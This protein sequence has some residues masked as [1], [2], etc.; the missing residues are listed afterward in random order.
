M[1]RIVLLSKDRVGISIDF[2]D[3]PHQIRSTILNVGFS[4]IQDALQAHW[5]IDAYLSPLDGEFDLNMAAVSADGQHYLV[6][7]MRTDCDVAF[8][9]MQCRALAYLQRTQTP[10]LVSKVVRTLEGQ[11]FER[12]SDETGDQR[13]IWVLSFI[14][15]TLYSQFEPVTVSLVRAL[16]EQVGQLHQA[17][18]GFDHPQLHRTFS[19]NLMQAEWIAGHFRH[20]ANSGRDQLL[21]SILDDYLQIKPV[22]EQLPY[23]AIHNDVN[24]NNIV[25]GHL[26][27]E[28]AQ[29]A[30]IIDFGDMCSAPRICDLAI[31]AA[32]VVLDRAD[33]G[34]AVAALVSGFHKHQP[35]TEAE[36]D[37][38]LPLLRLRLAVSV[39]TS[40]LLSLDRPNDPYLLVSQA[41]A[42]RFL[43]ADIKTHWLVERVRLACGLDV[44]S[45]AQRIRKYL[46]SQ[47]GHLLP[48]FGTSLEDVP[49]MTL[50]VDAVSIPKNPFRL[51]S[52]EATSLGGEGL[53]LGGYGEPRL[54]YTD[55]AFR[56]VPYNASK[57]RTVHLGVDVFAPA[58]TE[59]VVVLSGVVIAVENRTSHLD[60]GGLVVL[61][62]RNDEDDRFYSLYGH[63]DPESCKHLSVGHVVDAGRTIGRLGTSKC[64][65]GWAPHLHLQLA[66]SLAGMGIDWPGVACPD[67]RGLWCSLCPNPAALL[68][69]PDERIAYQPVD[70]VACRTARQKHFGP[71]L[72]LSYREP[73]LLLRGYR[74]YLF[75][76]WGR[77]YLDAYNNVPHV[78]HAHPD[79]QAVVARQLS[80]LNSNT[81][82]LHPAQSAFAEAVL[83]TMPDGL[84]VCYFVNSG[85]EANE[86]ALRLA[87]AVTGGKDV[88]TPNHGYH[89]NTTGAVDISAYKFNAPGGIGQAEWVQL[90]DSPDDYRGRYRRRECDTASCY[91]AQVDDALQRI[92]ARGGKLAGFIA[93]TFPS[94]AGQIIPPDGYLSQVYG[95]IRA[96]GGVCI[97]DEVQTGLGRLGAYFYGFEQQ[98]V[99]PDI[100][101]LGKPIGNGHP[102]G[103]VVTTRQIAESFAQGP[104]FFSTFGG[105]VL[106]CMIGKTVLDIVRHEGLQKNATNMG[107][108]LETGLIELQQRHE[109]IGDVRGMGLF[110]GLELVSD[111]RILS[112]ATAQAAHLVNRLRDK[113]ILA[114]LEGPD[115]NVLKIRPPLTI[116]ECDVDWLLENLENI[117]KET[118][119]N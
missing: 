45:G 3:Q 93:E 87:R 77:T 78:G 5:G 95:K 41:P 21:A 105:S 76:Q 74:H 92:E 90:V 7:V 59:V 88:I 72:K 12:V 42:W 22:L 114:G 85:S 18:A 33:P 61:E 108:R 43:E 16:G 60:Y 35:V 65:G 97:A 55:A 62:H 46:A 2:I 8:V 52:I 68:N 118:V 34:Q 10:V 111:R 11:D 49:V 14:N 81:R 83:A 64:N 26:A 98:E 53:S 110:V 102:L 19:W 96:A 86:L 44:V 36:I 106:S 50:S 115:N 23:V 25:I 113:R 58:G 73:L 66:L 104:E 32:Y 17:L 71:N 29:I 79:I 48:M 99:T 69:L 116:E 28:S 15:G 39:V 117:F 20:F 1:D 119:M 100:V 109:L 6:K 27:G 75:D 107:Q 13:L 54:V 84:S 94:V 112:P 40:S 91:A 101:V 56:A 4:V 57:R 30:G 67:D 24:D 63:L 103:V 80:R 31:A 89:G 38:L 47:C 37:L 70:E 51:D 82:Y 9:E